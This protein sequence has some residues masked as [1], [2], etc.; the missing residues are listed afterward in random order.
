MVR[1][2][3]VAPD[4]FPRV[5]LRAVWRKIRTRRRKPRTGTVNLGDLRRATPISQVFGFERGR[6]I[7]RRF[8]ESFLARHAEDIRGRVLEVGDNTYTTQ[9]GG[10]RVS[11]SDVLHL[12]EGA[13][14]A[15]LIG[16]L[17]DGDHLPSDAF[18]CILLTQTLHLVFDLEK[19]IATL[20][21][22]LRPG[23]VL[24]MT[25]PGVSSVDRGEWGFAWQWSFT[26]TSLRRLLERRFPAADTGIEVSG[27]VL[28]AIAFLHGL[29]DH[30]LDHSELDAHDPHYPV[31]VAARAI[32]EICSSAPRPAAA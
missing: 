18:D 31:I 14:Q 25:V 4:A 32:K 22:L 23:G 12:F 26:S 3:R 20:H 6:P 21:R 17:A 24:L 28:A 11:K 1:V 27:N 16:D 15:T 30:E 8:I 13:P 2:F 19:A 10:G 7:D 5:G 9:F 29:A